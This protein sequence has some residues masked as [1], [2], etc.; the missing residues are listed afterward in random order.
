MRQEV[1]VH[2]QRMDMH[3]FVLMNAFVRVTTLT[4]VIGLL[5]EIARAF[6]LPACP[7]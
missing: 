4:I 2:Y 7:Q 1:R 5:K 6:I 3:D